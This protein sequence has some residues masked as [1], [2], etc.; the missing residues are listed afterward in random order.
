M[1]NCA[2]LNDCNS[3]TTMSDDDNPQP[4]GNNAATLSG[5]TDVNGFGNPVPFA[6]TLPQAIENVYSRANWNATHDA[7]KNKIGWTVYPSEKYSRNDVTIII[8]EYSNLAAGGK[9]PVL[10]AAIVNDKK[11]LDAVISQIYGNAKKN[12]SRELQS[13]VIRT[14]LTEFYWACESE[15]ISIDR[16]FLNP[17]LATAPTAEDRAAMERA[18]DQ[19]SADA[20]KEEAERLKN[21]TSVIGRLINGVSD[22]FGTAVTTGKIITI[23]GATVVVGGLGLL[24]WTFAKKAGQV[25]VNRTISETQKTSR[26]MA[27]KI[28]L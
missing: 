19:K 1:S 12:S 26:S 23:G 8:N 2:S 6:T 4:Q 28:P 21:S 3:L 18:R 24:V 22:V 9:I 17:K 13:D 10:Q 15:P 20:Q 11:A 7:Y 5:I 27:G 14:I 16:I 25:D